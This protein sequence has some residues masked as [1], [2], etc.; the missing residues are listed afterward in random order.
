MAGPQGALQ[1]LVVGAGFMGSLHARVL[2]HTRRA[3]LV[4]V[5]DRREPVAREVGAARGVPGFTDLNEAI[6][7]TRPDA[8]V[9]ATP[10]P[11]HRV[12]TEVAVDAGLAVLV[13]KPLATTV[14]DA[15][16]MVAHA[17]RRGTRLMTGHL[18]RFHPRWAAVADTVRSGRLGRP[19]LV[20]AATWG[21]TSLGA[22]VADTTNPLWHFA[23]HDID[24]VRWATGGVV[25]EVHGA[26]FVTSTTGSS[27]FIATARLSTG[28]ALQL[29]TGWTFPGTG[30]PRRDLKVHCEHGVAEATWSS[31]GVTVTTAD[32][33]SEPDCMAW[34]ELHGRVAG[35]LHLELEHFVD[36]LLDD[37]EFVITPEEAVDA[38]RSAEALERAAATRRSL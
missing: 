28:A 32:D 2:Q 1:V 29:A 5:V 6:E 4:G 7:Q 13:E 35:A 3:N 31:D 30:H 14:P 21:F 37:T 24:T 11:A 12:P 36:A 19:V 16:A 17:G 8:A 10:D 9:I 22:R 25:E 27:A 20:T 38:V 34:P 18:G 26:Q 15:E 33:S 23:I